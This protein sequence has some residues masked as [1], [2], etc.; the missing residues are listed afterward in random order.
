MRLQVKRRKQRSSK[1]VVRIQHLGG[2]AAKRNRIKSRRLWSFGVVSKKI[3]IQSECRASKSVRWAVGLEGQPTV[4]PEDWTPSLVAFG[5]Q[6][7]I[8]CFEPD[9]IENL[10]V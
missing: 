6:R 10:F 2:F 1:I 8:S 4:N 7:A 9:L 3:N 5:Y